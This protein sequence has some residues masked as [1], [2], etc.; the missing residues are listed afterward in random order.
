[1]GVAGSV[2]TKVLDTVQ[3]PKLIFGG[4]DPQSSAQ[5][6]QVRALNLCVVA[7]EV[8]RTHPDFSLAS[9]AE[10]Q[11]PIPRKYTHTMSRG[12]L[13]VVVQDVLFVLGDHGSFE[14]PF[15][16]GYAQDSNHD[17]GRN[18]TTFS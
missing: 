4:L 13:L 1:M 8:Q 5:V 18:D 17:A 11:S 15:W 9:E 6:V 3:Q 2:A 10:D 7:L 12:A 14:P 16:F